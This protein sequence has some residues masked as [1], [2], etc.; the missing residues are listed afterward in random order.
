MSANKPLD[1]RHLK[2]V[3]H[4]NEMS[5]WFFQARDWVK[6][7]LETVLI[8]ALV[9]AAA[10]FGTRFLIQGQ[11]QKA[12]EASKALAAAQRTFQ[13]AV[14][15]DASEAGQAF[16]QAYAAYQGVASTYEGMVEAKVARLGMAHSL[17]A[18]GKFE[19]ALRDYTALDSGDATDPVAELAALGKA[20]ALEAQGKTAEALQAYQAVLRAYPG[21]AGEREAQKRLKELQK[22]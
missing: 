15:A 12:L 3:L 7:H 5:E 14:G 21:G 6:G 9:A 17:L 2:E 4:R 18:Q 20:R 11:R 1:R 22:R 16:A 8:S 19:E 10:I 13:Q